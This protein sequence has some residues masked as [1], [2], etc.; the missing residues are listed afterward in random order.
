MSREL[1]STLRSGFPFTAVIHCYGASEVGVDELGSL[2]KHV[3]EAPSV[4]D[5]C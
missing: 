1:E 3:H 4:E 2:V 5:T